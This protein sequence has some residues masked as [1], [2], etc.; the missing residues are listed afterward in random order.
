[1]FSRTLQAG[2]AAARVAGEGKR[3]QRPLGR[4]RDVFSLDVDAKSIGD[5]FW[6]FLR[7]PLGLPR[8]C[9][10]MFADLCKALVALL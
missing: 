4:Q 7:D 10:S 1:V 9:S 6:N 2:A 8:I 5:V 3:E